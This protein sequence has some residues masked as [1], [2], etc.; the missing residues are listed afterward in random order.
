MIR[1]AHGFISV[2]VLLGA[3]PGVAAATRVAATPLGAGAGPVVARFGPPTLATSGGEGSGLTGT[4][5]LGADHVAGQQC[6]DGGF[7]WPHD[8]CSATYHNITAPIALGQ[9]DS[10]VVSKE[11]AHLISAVNG[12][13]FDMTSQYPN[14]EARFGTF[15]P[16]FLL[17][18]ANATGYTPFENFAATAFFGQLDAGTYGPSDLDT[19]G[20]IG[21]VQAARVGTWIN[22]LPWEFHTL[23]PASAAIGVAGQ[24]DLFEQ[25]L[26]DGLDTL[27]NTDPDNVYVDILG[28]AG[29]V[30]GLAL[31]GRTTFPPIAAPLHPGI[32]GIDTLEDLAAYLASLQNPDGSWYHHSNLPAPTVDDE[33]LQVTA[34]ATLALVAAN[35]QTSASYSGALT[36]ARDWMVS[37]QSV[38]GGFPSNPGGTE[39]TEV[40]GEAL[41]A[42][43]EASYLF[44]DGFE[45]GDTSAWSATLP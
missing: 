36:A 44:G 43:F 8:D 26:L 1:R 35:P 17:R 20:F 9:L 37:Q 6:A 33:D 42:I 12:G 29:G 38:D 28:I 10:A 31:A 23:I 19:A 3:G 21:Y 4:R 14:G 40:E 39:N 5:A 32:D 11:S 7:G 16:W 24:S 30:R 34:Y 45:S 18:L 25:A 22:L 13:I 2:L 41:S 15:T 27:D